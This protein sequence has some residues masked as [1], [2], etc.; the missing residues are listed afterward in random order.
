MR[1]ILTI[2]VIT[3]SP[4]LWCDWSTPQVTILLCYFVELHQKIMERVFEVYSKKHKADNMDEDT[5]M[6]F[7]IDTGT[8]TRSNYSML[9]EYYVAFARWM[10]N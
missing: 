4:N 5:N 3:S 2:A 9:P 10:L 7:G 6:R 1:C 8:N